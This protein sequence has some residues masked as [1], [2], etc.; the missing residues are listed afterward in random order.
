MAATA[1]PFTPRSTKA[2]NQQ[3]R[4][5]QPYYD[6]ALLAKGFS[7][8]LLVRGVLRVNPKNRTDAYVSLDETPNAAALYVR[9]ELANYDVGLGND[10]YICG[11]IDRNRAIS[12]DTVAIRILDKGQ[13]FA[14]QDARTTPL[15]LDEMAESISTT[16]GAPATNTDAG[17]RV[18]EI[19]GTIVA[20]LMPNED[21]CFAG[22]LS[23]QPPA[24][25]KKHPLFENSLDAPVLWFRPINNALP[26]MAV[27]VAAVP[28]ALRA[29]S[30]RH[31][32]TVRMGDWAAYAP[33][34]SATFFK[35]LGERGPLAIETMLILEDNGVCSDPFKP[36]VLR[37]LPQT[38]WRIPAPELSRRT[39]LRSACI[40]TIDPPTARDLDDAVSCDLLPNG[41]V[42]IGVHIADVSY[43]VRPKTALD[44]Q[45]RQRATTTYMD[46]CSL[47]PGVDRLAFSIMWEMDPCDAT[48]LSTWF[49][50]TI[51]NSACKLAY[52][53]AQSVI[54]GAHLSENIPQ[55]QVIGGG[56]GL[57]VPASASRRAQIE[58]S[59]HWFYPLDNGALSLSSVRLSF[60]LDDAG[61]PTSC[62]P[63]A[64]K[65][66]NRLIE[67]FMLL[68]NMSVA[69]R[70]EATFPDAALLRRHS[71]PLARR[72]DET[73]KQLQH[74]G[75][76]I[77][78]ASSRD[79]QASLDL[80]TDPDIRSTVECMLTGPMQ[81]AVYFSTHT[82]KD[83]NGYA[84]YALDVP[85]YTHFTSPIRRYADIIVHRMLEASLAVFGNH[86]ATDHPL[87]PAY[88]SPYFPQTPAAGSL[89]TVSTE[90]LVPAPEVVADIAH[91]CNLRKD[92]AK[93]AQ[94]ASAHLY[95]VHYL[96]RRATYSAIPTTLTSA[97]VT[98]IKQDG[99]VVTLPM[100]G[101]ETIMYMDRMAD[102][103][104]QVVSTDARDWKLRVWSV[105]PA[106]LTL[107]WNV[108]AQ[109]PIAISAAACDDDSDVLVSSMDSKK[110]NCRS[111]P[112]KLTQVTVAMLPEAIPP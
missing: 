91:R 81:R 15:R 16:P 85:L 79:I 102:K 46:L 106:E 65:D 62:R 77:N 71:P 80:I 24:V 1:P 44:L 56:S 22:T 66:S 5:F 30:K 59:I 99:F 84:H 40:F 47:N 69:A 73:C 82:I 100:Y 58:A 88:H 17:P 64:I 48:V 97:V 20:V 108:F 33:L 107:V 94:D 7:T 104:N 90:L 86:V 26:Q 96:M 83:R 60:D 51:I 6:A 110:V 3:P 67:E 28:K 50:R 93:K 78:P 52:D 55:Y 87:L 9:P 2:T 32:C 35:D 76:D 27:P 42:R 25:L 101:I 23:S 4:L 72:L 61:N 95:L 105:D 14:S 29:G 45:A 12:G 8:G 49:G 74:I 41:N 57:P 103:E 112:T 37:C 18:P 11:D 109:E 92:A 19:F 98:K 63:Y 75:I 89:T 111:A 38:P 70:I 34:P 21:R 36:V 13:A 43:F 53:D 39:D 54:D 68:A 10:I 31:Y